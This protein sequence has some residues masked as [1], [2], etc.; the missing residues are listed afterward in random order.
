MGRYEFLA[1]IAQGGM[2][3]VWAARQWGSRGFSKIVAVKTMLPS[4]SEDPRFERMFLDEARIA[5]RIHHDNVVEILDL[6]EQD[7][8]LYLVM[9][10]VDGESLSAVRR[11]ASE[12]GGI[13]TAIAVRIVADACAG[14]HAAHELCDD[15]GQQFGIVHRDVSPQNILV[16]YDG[17]VK[18]LDF[19][20]AKVAGRTSDT[21]SVGQARGKPPYMAPEQALGHVVDRR[22]DIFSLGIVL[23][24]LITERHPFRGENDIATLHNIISEQPITSPTAHVPTLPESLVSVM[25]RALERDVERRFQSARELELALENLLD[26]E[27]GRV[28]SEEIGAAMSRWIGARGEDRRFSLREAI[29]KADLADVTQV[30]V[31]ILANDGRALGATSANLMAGGVHATELRN[32]DLSSSSNRSPAEGARSRP[33]MSGIIDGDS[34]SRVVRRDT[35]MADD[36]HSER[37]IVELAPSWHTQPLVGTTILASRNSERVRL[38]HLPRTALLVLIAMSVGAAMAWGSVLIYGHGN[39][40]GLAAQRRELR[41]EPMAT[42][43]T[44]RATPSNSN[45]EPVPAASSVVTV[46]SQTV[47]RSPSRS[48]VPANASRK[49]PTGPTFNLPPIPSP[50][51]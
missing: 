15:D 47:P 1:P 35:A 5:S 42:V 12:F 26:R 18:V 28:R 48:K 20:V 23:Y 8:V 31:A 36:D 49:R 29:R 11:A 14:L 16:G 9:E 37:T 19:G 39:R 7:S 6:G 4:I 2:A 17:G 21:T 38:R 34:Q 22:A 30:Q 43:T 25:L 24:Q 46:P 3:S 32:T 45:K 33:D 13:P 27:L 50:G 40:K 10:W 51:F 41:T 44:E